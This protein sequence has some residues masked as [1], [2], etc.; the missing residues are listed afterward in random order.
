MALSALIDAPMTRMPFHVLLF[1][2]R[3]QKGGGMRRR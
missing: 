2:V 3:E 1:G